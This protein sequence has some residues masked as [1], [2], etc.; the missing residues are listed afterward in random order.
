MPIYIPASSVGE[1][2][3]LRV[4]QP[5]NT[6][7]GQFFNFRHFT[8]CV[9][10]SHHGFNLH[11]PNDGWREPHSCACL[12]S[13]SLQSVSA[14]FYCLF[15]LSCSSGSLCI[16]VKVLDQIWDFQIF[17]LSLWFAFR[18]EVLFFDGVHFTF[19][20]LCLVLWYLI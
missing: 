16:W 1:L 20:Y 5:P 7:H 11:F 6:W 14:I 9:V 3:A 19:F 8:R 13:V 15:F 4:P 18:T 12:L 10:V 17:P 2:Q